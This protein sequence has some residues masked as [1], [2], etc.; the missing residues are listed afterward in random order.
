MNTS[1]EARV[2][3]SFTF[4][5]AMIVGAWTGVERLILGSDLL[6]SGLAVSS[7]VLLAVML[8]ATA[9]AIQATRATELAW[10]RAL[11]G[12]AGLLGVLTVLASLVYLLSDS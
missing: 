12:A 9:V 2:I 4:I 5:A 1:A 7:L 6:P 11:G 8:A 10:A 3:A